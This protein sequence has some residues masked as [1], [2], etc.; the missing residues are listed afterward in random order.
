MNKMN[1]FLSVTA[2]LFCFFLAGCQTEEAVQVSSPDGNITARVFLMDNGQA[3]Y[4][5]HHKGEPVIDKSTLGFEFLDAPPLATGL[6]VTGTAK[7]SFSETW[8]MPWGE[9]RWVDNTY[10]ELTV[11]LRETGD[12]ARESDLIF[13][14]Y[15]DGLGFRFSFPDQEHMQE[16]LITEE[17]TW[18]NLT[19]DHMVWW[20]PGD[21]D[22]YE[23][24]YSTTPF[25]EINALEKRDHPNLAQT[26]IPVNA[27]NTP[28]TMKTD[29]G[30]HISF[31]EAALIDYS[32]ITLEIDADNLKMRSNL[33]GTGRE[34]YKVI[35]ET[36][37]STPWRTI[38][39]AERA[40]DLIESRLM[41][42]LNE[43]NKLGDVSWLKPCKYMGIW[44]EMHIGKSS[45][46]YTDDRD[47]NSWEEAEPHGRH[48]ATTENAEYYIDFAA[49]HGIEAL[50]IEG[51][52]TGWEHWIGHEDR[53][54]IFDFVTPYPDFDLDKVTS[55]AKEKG[56]RL[57]MHHETSAAV[58]TYEEQMDT[59]Y[60]LMEHYGYDMVKTGYVGTIIPVGEYHHG[61]WM[62]NHYMRVLEKA[63]E[64]QV[65]VNI[66]EPI[67]A[68]GLRR[69]Y[70]ND[71][72]REGLRGQEFNAW[73]TDGGNPPEHLPIVAFTRML[74]GPIDYTPGIFNIKLD[75]Y[76]PDNQVN[77]TLAQ[78]LALY[79]VIYSPMQ[80]VADLPQH[81]EGH[82]AFQ[83]IKD[84]GVDWEQ[85]QVLNGE[86]GEYV[87]I[88]RKERDTGNWF[89]GSITNED[90][91]QLIIRTDFLEPGEAYQATIYADGA[92]AHWDDN[93]ES[94][95][96]E[97]MTVDHSSEIHLELAPGG[98][99]AISFREQPPGQTR[100]LWPGA[101]W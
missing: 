3:A 86:I 53:E 56:V 7:R 48:G 16:V 41:V 52:Y 85:S 19:G 50:L 44:W 5:V 51:W 72:T 66:H 75:P 47:F 67:M 78:Q 57:V 92:D 10:N 97:S 26:Y 90:A 101:P 83:F 100:G 59:A 54:G 32:G 76:Q 35:Q 33:V 55:Y 49:E 82:P 81:Y 77:T 13:R 4:T 61:Q 46:D 68:T 99:A 20:T 29:G 38:Q 70:P 45:W 40:G 65:M 27:V 30:L 24:L 98:G 88:A 23:H 37:F 94:Y 14:V 1:P 6:E 73:A 28:V 12:L 58:T 87:T 39:I 89:L 74:A 18:F 21:W 93:P 60:A 79:V 71:A 80:M 15:D 25:T 84:V 36:P 17:N 42:N 22:I 2:L 63:A 31:H 8:E 9:Q 95:H 64:H 62:V 69:T 43:P 96:I 34:E 91:R 11:S